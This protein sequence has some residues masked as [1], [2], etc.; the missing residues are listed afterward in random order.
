ML[1]SLVELRGRY[2]LSTSS[3]RVLCPSKI[4]RKRDAHSAVGSAGIGLVLAAALIESE[5]TQAAPAKAMLMALP[6]QLKWLLGPPERFG[7]QNS[8][9]KITISAVRRRA[10]SGAM[11]P[12]RMA[13]AAQK[14]PMVV[15]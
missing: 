9:S 15:A 5:T 4:E 10:A 11:M 3:P 14:K 6:A 7:I 12:V 8:N 2:R 1:T 13:T